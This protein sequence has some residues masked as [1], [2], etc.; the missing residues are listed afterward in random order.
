MLGVE[1][2]PGRSKGPSRMRRLLSRWFAALLCVAGAAVTAS[3]DVVDLPAD[4]YGV[5]APKGQTLPTLDL[6][7]PSSLP[8]GTAEERSVVPNA[9]SIPTPTAFHAGFGLMVALIVVRRLRRTTP[10]ARIAGR[11]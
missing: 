6:N 4:V 7:P 1:R 10:R 8:Q 3:A 11:G 9:Q 2:S 5:D